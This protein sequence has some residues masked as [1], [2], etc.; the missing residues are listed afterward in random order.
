[1]AGRHPQQ[2]S[3]TESEIWEWVVGRLRNHTQS[4]GDRLEDYV[5][6]YETD[7]L[8]DPSIVDLSFGG[9]GGVGGSGPGSSGGVNGWKSAQVVKFKP[10]KEQTAL[11]RIRAM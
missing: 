1:M 2:S 9:S 6:V 5:D 4:S 10:G 11:E 8:E 3:V 7:R